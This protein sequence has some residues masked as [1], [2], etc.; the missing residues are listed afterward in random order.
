MAK[1]NRVRRVLKWAGLVGCVALVVVW[2]VSQFG[3]VYINPSWAFT[4]STNRVGVS[5]SYSDIPPD[6]PSSGQPSLIRWRSLADVSSP[7]FPFY[8]WIG[9]KTLSTD[10]DE[11]GIDYLGTIWYLFVPFWCPLVLLAIP[12]YIL[13]RRDRKYPPGYCQEC[14][15]DLTGNVSGVC[16]ECGTKIESR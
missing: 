9:Q 7:P 2:I 5:C 8:R 1:R 16:P 13:W 12:T 6:L 10:Y 15:Y 3:M 4:L 11:T 14:A